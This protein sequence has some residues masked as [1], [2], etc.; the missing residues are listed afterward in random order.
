MQLCFEAITAAE[1]AEAE[2]TTAAAAAAAAAIVSCSPVY[3][4]LTGELRISK[5][6]KK[7][8]CLLHSYRPF[9][10]IS[11]F[12]QVGAVVLIIRGVV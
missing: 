5:S 4:N 8:V 9:W 7:T 11:S 6:K 10:A 12:R 1:E 3:K 2:T